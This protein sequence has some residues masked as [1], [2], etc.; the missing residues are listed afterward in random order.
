MLR[1]SGSV[2]RRRATNETIPRRT[3]S[4]TPEIRRYKPNRSFP[5]RVRI[6]GPIF[7]TRRRRWESRAVRASPLTL[8]FSNVVRRRSTSSHLRH[9]GRANKI[10][11]VDGILPPRTENYGKAGQ[12]KFPPKWG[13][14]CRSGQG[15]RWNLRL[16]VGACRNSQHECGRIN[17]SRSSFVSIAATKSRWGLAR[18]I[19]LM[20]SGAMVRSPQQAAPW[21]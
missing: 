9:L 5:C 20:R 19:C 18:R 2:C 14:G 17:H 16:P 8:R 3:T 1:Q 13:P 12:R 11:Q 6:T 21:I 15:G 7:A 4:R 10:N